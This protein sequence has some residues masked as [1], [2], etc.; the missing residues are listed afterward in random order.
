MCGTG[1]NDYRN[2]IVPCVCGR[3]ERRPGDLDQAGHCRDN[4]VTQDVAV[5][6]TRQAV[7]CVDYGFAVAN[8]SSLRCPASMLGRL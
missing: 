7:F 8:F 3:L 4:V 6:G 5:A 1:V 2:L